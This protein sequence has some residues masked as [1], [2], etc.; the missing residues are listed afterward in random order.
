MASLNAAGSRFA[1]R[2]LTLV[3]MLVVL[4]IVAILGAVVTV[5]S[6]DLTGRRA[7]AAAEN[8]QLALAQVLRLGR[9]G[10][11][12]QLTWHP[13]VVRFARL[14]ATEENRQALPAGARIR[15]LWVDGTPWPAGEVLALRGGTSPLLRLELDVGEQ[16][17]VLRSLPTGRVERQAGS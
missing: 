17:W 13:D 7:E 9:A 1:Q 8:L 11:E 2:G 6:M 16:A 14:G 3:E 10:D 15:G 5:P 4:A 12:W